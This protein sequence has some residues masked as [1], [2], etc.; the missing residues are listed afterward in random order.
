LTTDVAL[1][2]LTG[3]ARSGKSRLAIELAARRA[4]PVVVVA[5]GEALD[6]EMTERI[7][8]HREER[9]VEWTTVEEPIELERAVA[10]AP[11]DAFVVVDCLSLWI[12]NLMGRELPADQILAR[13]RDAA[14]TSAARAAGTVAVSNE[15]GSAIVPD[16]ALARRYRDLLGLVNATWAA[17]AARVGLVV[18]GRLLPLATAD[19]VWRKDEGWITS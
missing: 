2:L 15:V 5:T 6:D 19:E 9:P 4:G 8:R 1:L 10:E 3:G 12:A 14:A 7:R 13:A 11:T 17:A 16:N 18:A